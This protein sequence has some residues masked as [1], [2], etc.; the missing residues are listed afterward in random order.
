MS[1][2]F[3][4]ASPGAGLDVAATPPAPV[5][6]QIEATAGWRRAERIA[7]VEGEGTAEAPPQVW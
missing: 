4:D 1:K 5:A 2:P 3:R 7:P 6:G